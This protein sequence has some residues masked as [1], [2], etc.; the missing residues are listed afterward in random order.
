[1]AS[2]DM[3][4]WQSGADAIQGSRSCLLLGNDDICDDEEISYQ[5]NSQSSFMLGC[6]DLQ[7]IQSQI[8]MDDAEQA[9]SAS[10]QNEASMSIPATRWD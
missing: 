6:D 1:M 5:L 3:L 9:C 2:L 10:H 7:L 8:R 4:P